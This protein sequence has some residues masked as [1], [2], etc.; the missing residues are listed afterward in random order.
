MDSNK[1]TKT[2]FANYP[3]VV[4]VDDLINMLNIGRNTAYSLLKD[5]RIKSIRI[6]KRYIIPKQ[7]V[8][9]FLLHNT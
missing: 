1:N 3:D 5:G 7:N 4:V 6:G 9:D 8:I 2:Y